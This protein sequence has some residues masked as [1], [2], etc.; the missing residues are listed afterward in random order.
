M[1][2]FSRHPGKP[3][4]KLVDWRTLDL[5]RLQARLKRDRSAKPRIEVSAH[6]TKMNNL[7]V[8]WHPKGW[9]NA[10]FDWH[11]T[12]RN[13]FN[14]ITRRRWTEPPDFHWFEGD[15]EPTFDSRPSNELVYLRGVSNLRPEPRDTY[16]PYA[17][18]NDDVVDSIVICTVRAAYEGLIEQLKHSFDVDVINAFDFV[19]REEIHG[20]DELSRR[21]PAHRVVAWS[22]E[23]AAELEARRAR[24]ASEEH[25]RR[26]REE[27]ADLPGRY[28]LTIESFVN[29]LLLASSKKPTGPAPSSKGINR[30]A[31]KTLRSAGSK[32]DAADVRRIR[33]LLGVYAL[34][35][36]SP[37]RQKFPLLIS[38][39]NFGETKFARFQRL[40][41]SIGRFSTS[42]LANHYLFNCRKY[43]QQPNGFVSE[44]TRDHVACPIR[45]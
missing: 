6:I 31:A 35:T 4:A 32:V 33:Q 41:A 24:D 21:F 25:E 2:W 17:T 43:R 13:H 14:L 42:A 44:V 12:D 18:F 15:E 3:Y 10:V 29:A 9:R 36:D 1:D 37:I 23:D 5:P 30:N 40:S 11:R 26:D 8:R 16:G 22:L 45:F 19:L 28:G 38:K 27:L 20:D 7:S 39:G 34:R